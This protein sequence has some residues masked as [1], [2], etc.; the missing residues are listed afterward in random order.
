MFGKAFAQM[1]TGSMFGKPAAVFAVWTYIIAHMR[2]LRKNGECHCEVNPA[3]L[4]ATFSAKPEDIEAAL[5]DLESPDP[6]SRSKRDEGRRIVLLDDERRSGPRQYRVVNGAVYRAIR[7]DE[8]R[9]EQNRNAKRAERQR[10]RVSNVSNVSHGQPMSAQAE[11]EVEEE[12]KKKTRVRNSRE[13]APRKRVAT[14][15]PQDFRPDA[16]AE[17]LAQELGLDLQQQLDRFRA[18]YSANGKRFSDW[19]AAFQSWL[20]KA[21]DF[22]R[23]PRA[24]GTDSRSRDIERRL[25]K[26]AARYQD[27]KPT[28]ADDDEDDA[29]TA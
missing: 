23:T 25:E 13:S 14:A 11:V 12:A 19:Q 1:Y 15:L 3:L 21:P 5:L 6:A 9:R 10:K 28:N 17:K 26:A 18:H 2:P 27:I 22:E 24:K 16:T 29:V 8:Q 4:A 7:D 20:H